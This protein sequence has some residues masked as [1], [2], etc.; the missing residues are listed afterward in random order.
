[1]DIHL[2]TPFSRV[3]LE[4]ILT[5][6]YSRM[7]I[8]W[9]P[10]LFK[11]E[12]AKTNFTKPWIYPLTIS[13]DAPE[14]DFIKIG[15]RKINYFLKNYPILGSDY[16]CFPADDDMYEEG[17]FDKIKSIDADVVVISLKRGDQVPPNLPKNRRYSTYSLMAHPDNMVKGRVS[18]EQLIIK[19]FIFKLISFDESDQASDG[20]VAEYLKASNYNIHYEPD[21]YGLFNYYEPG[22]YNGVLD[23]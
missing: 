22:R 12:L 1:M 14:S 7:N 19:G 11:D 17:V 6:A 10:I 21:L 13:E 3:Y 2:I 5:A 4:N 9:H 16:Y 18:G 23:A 15:A 20:A 8:L